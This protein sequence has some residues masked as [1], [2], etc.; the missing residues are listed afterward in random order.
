ML[1]ISIALL[2]FV[3]AF[4]LWAAAVWLR[5]RFGESNAPHF[6]QYMKFGLLVGTL[7][8]ISFSYCELYEALHFRSR[9]NEI[10]AVLRAN[11]LALLGFILLGYFFSGERISRGSLLIY[12]VFSCVIYI[13]ERITLITILRRE[14]TK[15]QNQSRILLVGEGEAIEDY[16]RI[17]NEHR[18]LGIN[19]VGWADGP[20]D[21]N[22][23]TIPRGAFRELHSRYK[24]DAVVISYPPERSNLI[25]A[26][27]RD[28][29]NDLTKIYVLPAFHSYA[30]LGL[31]LEDFAGLP[32]LAVNQP[33]W[34]M[35]DVVAK[36]LLDFTGAFC[37]LLVLSPVLLLLSILVKLTSPGPIFFGQ[38]RMGLDGKTFKMWKFRSMKAAPPGVATTGWT[39]ANDPRRTKF[40]TFLR[41]TSLDELPQFWNVLVG[42][43]SLVG[44]RPEQPHYVET[45]KDKIPAYMLRHKMKAGITGWAQV[46]GW[47]GDTS[48]HRRIECDLY[49]IKNWSLTLD[50]KILLLTVW[51]GFVNRN[52]Y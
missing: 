50:F 40:G 10:F 1:K 37:G 12:A 36:R 27:L 22:T 43:M 18:Q 20:S 6:M 42:D 47:R 38:E 30:L 52:A 45:F 14:K 28:N 9:T 24:P 26:F 33:E 21:Q 5:I 49:Y 3:L 35:R 19:V 39:V 7:T 17:V 15:I 2:D 29:Y 32:I 11:F 44:P 51:K 34:R 13:V 31:R 23:S 4:L 46:N 41:S 25:D 16:I 8:V 48:L